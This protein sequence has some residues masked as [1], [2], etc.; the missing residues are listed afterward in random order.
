MGHLQKRSKQ[1]IVKEELEKLEKA[2]YISSDVHTQVVE[3]HDQY[4]ADLEQKEA[5]AAKEGPD[6]EAQI[7]EQPHEVQEKKPIKEKKTLSPKE[8]RERNITW[9]LNLGV[10]LL[11]IGGLVLA[12]S[13][14]ETLAN[15]MK[16]GM[17]ALVSL[18]FFG[19][20]VFTERML[21]IEKTAFAFYVLGALFLPIAILSVGFFELLGPYFS[22]TGGGRYLFGAAGSAVIL[23][24]YIAL[25]DKRSSRLFVWFSYITVTVLAG[26]LLAAFD[27]P[28]DGFYLGIMLF[29]ALLL[30]IYIRLKD[31][32]RTRLFMKE[33]VL[34]IQCNLV[35]STLLM[36]IFYNHEVLYGFNVLLT[37]VLYFAM[38]YVTEHKEYSFVFSAMLVYGAYQLIEFTTVEDASAIVYALLGFVFLTIPRLIGD[39][40]ALKRIF[41][42]TSAVVSACAFLYISLEGL[43]LRMHEPSFVLLLAYVLIAFNFTFLANQTKRLL[44]A[45]LSPVFLMGALY[46]V[47]LF[48]REWF[49]YDGLML[50]LFVMGLVLYIGFGCLIKMALFQTMKRSSRDVGGVVLLVAILTDFVL[51]N[52][53][54]AGT[55]LL[56]IS[57]TTLLTKRYEGRE[58]LAKSSSWIHA[59]SLGLAVMMFYAETFGERTSYGRNPMEAESF[60]LAGLV[61]LLASIGWKY[62]KRTMFA[63]HSFFA[64]YG[65][66]VLGIWL[67]FTFDFDAVL[68]AVIMLGGVAMA[69]L[70]YRKTKW[71]AV[72]YVVSGMSLLFYMTAL[73]AVHSEMT[74][75]SDL[76]QSLQ[77]VIGALLLLIAGVLIG[78]YDAGLR[79]SFWWTGHLFLPFASLVSL[80][81]FAEETVWAFLIAAAVYGLSLR[82][83]R[84]EWLIG[85]FL[86]GG[87]TAFWIGVTQ[88]FVLLDAPESIQY[89]ALLTSVMIA[90]G[91]YFSKGAWT[92]RMAFYVV[93][94]SVLGMFL[95]VIV[96]VF[97]VTL[98]VVTLLYAVMTLFIMHREKWDVFTALPL[99]LVYSTLWLYDGTIFSTE[100]DMLFRL[101]VFAG[102][103]LAAG[104]LMYPV[105]YQE[106]RDK[107]IPVK[108]DWYSVIGFA[109]L[110]SIYVVPAEAFWAKLLPGL[111]VS[112]YLILQRKRTPYVSAKWI[113]FGACIY[114]LQPYYVLLGNIQIFD[115]IERELYVLP[116]VA[117]VIFLKKVTDEKYNR[118]VNYGQWAVLVIV[119]LLLIQDGMASSTIYDA[120][121]V[122]VLSLAS[123]LGGMAYQ[124]KA[125]FFVGAGVLLLNVFL[126]TRPYWGNL[127]WWAYLLIAG[128][129]LIA[130]ASYNEWHKQKTADGRT[131][132][133]SKFYQKVVQRIKRWE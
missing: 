91:W 78:K 74:I 119:S 43:V 126:Q 53:W 104:L 67:T 4:Y 1:R 106:Q 84:A 76:F 51:I 128:S 70:L 40:H 88:G 25:A 111:L 82:W 34:Y 75:Q 130:V 114:L 113:V 81:F 102:L 46:E 38:I 56:F 86:Y 11:L 116:W 20:A 117:A 72:S 62:G 133:A 99:A 19:L 33:F 21:K 122:G 54:Q 41:R 58:A 95:F 132:L 9:S 107:E 100:Y 98:F 112:L 64:A 79:K 110:C 69:Y 125:F 92:R 60:V 96:P 5:E 44:F 55:M 15:W 28:V 17:I 90:I 31:N 47:A 115:L 87:F 105:T 123:M 45:Y 42:Y 118:L 68:R 12:T 52:W 59:V 14:W 16:S 80:V 57:I 24:I 71:M 26:F 35:L 27:L 3:A 50:P 108:I 89:A 65:F 66:Y 32:Q 6:R 7:E 48:G 101:V 109:A 10:V 131:T 103:L 85:S 77:F 127:P 2:E 121:I 22:F 73:Y 30:L 37:A 93:P 120:L 39:D 129:I 124:L 49:G 94:F 23:P 18:L 36:L 61:V 8:L 63:E 97:D 83:A 29:N 13:T